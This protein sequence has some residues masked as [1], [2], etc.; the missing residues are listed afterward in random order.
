MDLMGYT[1]GNQTWRAGQFP[2]NGGVD[3]KIIYT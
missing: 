3:G 2:I 1:F